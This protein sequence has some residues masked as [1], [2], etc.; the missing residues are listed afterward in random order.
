MFLI[1]LTFENFIIQILK[2][3]K[4]FFK[5]TNKYTFNIIELLSFSLSFSIEFKKVKD[6]HIF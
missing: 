2:I 1:F 4:I 3:L 6:C 5:I